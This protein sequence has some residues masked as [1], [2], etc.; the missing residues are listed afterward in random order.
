MFSLFE[1]VFLNSVLS[2]PQLKHYIF[3]FWKVKRLKKT[4]LRV[5]CF[6]HQKSKVKNQ[7][8]G[9]PQIRFSG[10]W[11]NLKSKP[12]KIWARL[13]SSFYNSS[14]QWGKPP[15]WTRGTET[16]EW[17][18]H[19]HCFFFFTLALIFWVGKKPR[20]IFF[21][22]PKTRSLIK[23]CLASLN[24]ENI[25]KFKSKPFSVNNEK[26]GRTGCDTGPR[27]ATWRSNFSEN[28]SPGL[29]N[30]PMYCAA[31]GPKLRRIFFGA[32]NVQALQL[33]LRRGAFVID[34]LFTSNQCEE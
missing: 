6:K 28:T 31:N 11:V 30:H 22:G 24:E 16:R 20:D 9:Q 19:F 14:L 18:T 17:R 34:V 3:Y 10:S 32:Q 12:C 1:H 25:P 27:R 5:Y 4:Q 26:I 33:S 7:Y 2:K 23:V 21:K 29:W 8:L 15:F 13:R